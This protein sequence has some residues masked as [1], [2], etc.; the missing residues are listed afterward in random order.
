[1][2]GDGEKLKKELFRKKEAAFDNLGV[3]PATQMAKTVK[4]RKPSVGDACFRKKT[5]FV[6]G[7][8]FS[9]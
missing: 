3:S 7:Q 1:M 4:M 2:Q 8:S 5:N 6:A 9:V